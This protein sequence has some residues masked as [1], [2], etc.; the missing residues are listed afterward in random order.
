MLKIARCDKLFSSTLGQ[1]LSFAPMY[2][3]RRAGR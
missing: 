3:M 2:R 1:S